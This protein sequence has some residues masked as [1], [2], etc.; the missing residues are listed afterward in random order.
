[1]IDLCFI[2]P[3]YN[4][5]QTIE[6]TLNSVFSQKTT[7]KFEVIVIDNGSTDTTRDIVGKFDLALLYESVKGANHAR[8]LGIK[9]ANSK[10]VAFVDSDVVLAE[11]WMES[12]LN[13]IKENKLLA[14]QGQVVLKGLDDSLLNRYRTSFTNKGPSNWIS[15]V[16]SNK[17]V[18]HINTAAC[19]Y[20]LKTLR[21]VKGFSQTLPI[22]EDVDLTYKIRSLP[23][24]SIGAT[25]FAVAHCFYSG[26]MLSY[27]KRAL[28][29]GYYSALLRK[30]WKIS[31]KQ[32]SIMMVSKGRGSNLVLDII[33]LGLSNIGTLWGQI[34]FS[35]VTPTGLAHEQSFI[36]RISSISIRKTIKVYFENIEL[37][38]M[39]T[40][41]SNV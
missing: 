5:A 37:D 4:S 21:S 41:R 22:H 40:P 28:V 33:L 25:A 36:E 24:G 12:L 39:T 10:Y 14:A 6:K 3:C 11:D 27:F 13:Y 2:I 20:E 19:I 29:Y 7:F 31:S 23:D 35:I 1:M 26:S 8:N 17:N 34:V 9:H 18:G 38:T 15:L 30:K 32:E 16:T